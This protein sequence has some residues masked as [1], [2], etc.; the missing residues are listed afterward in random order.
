MVATSD[1]FLLACDKVQIWP[2]NR[3]LTHDTTRRHLL[4][5]GAIFDQSTE[6][7]PDQ[8]SSPQALILFLCKGWWIRI[9]SSS[10]HADLSCGFLCAK[11]DFVGDSLCQLYR[12]QGNLREKICGNLIGKLRRLRRNL[13]GGGS[14]SSTARTCHTKIQLINFNTC[15]NPRWKK[16]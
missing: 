12:R 9:G 10:S 13:R 2:T 6:G 5:L 15:S 7:G 3:G 11:P 1:M 16:N 14:I 8:L 4:P